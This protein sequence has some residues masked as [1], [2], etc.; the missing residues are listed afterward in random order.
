MAREFSDVGGAGLLLGPA[1]GEQRIDEL[2]DE[3]AD[4]GGE[5]PALLG[6]GLVGDEGAVDLPVDL[7]DRCERVGCAEHF[8]AV[9]G[10]RDV[11][12]GGVLAVD[13]GEAVGVRDPTTADRSRAG[14]AAGRR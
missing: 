8:G 14:V 4:L 3:L 13:G 9:L 10:E 12:R 2:A 1:G 7:L 6:D 5:L 11:D